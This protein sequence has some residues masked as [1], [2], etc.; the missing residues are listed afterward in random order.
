M[1]ARMRCGNERCMHPGVYEWREVEVGKLLGPM[2]KLP[3]SAMCCTVLYCTVLL[4]ASVAFTLSSSR[5]RQPG[6]SYH[7]ARS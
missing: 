4:L 2:F 6:V 7:M 3:C 1:C 5:R